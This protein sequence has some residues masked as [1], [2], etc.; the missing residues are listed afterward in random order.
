[1]FIYFRAGSG[2]FRSQ[3]NKSFL[4]RCIPK[5]FR[6]SISVRECLWHCA[7]GY[8]WNHQFW[9]KMCEGSWNWN[10]I[11][12]APSLTESYCLRNGESKKAGKLIKWWCSSPRFWNSRKHF[13]LMKIY[14]N[15]KGEKP[16]FMPHKDSSASKPS[17][18]SHFNKNSSI[19]N[20]ALIM[21]SHMRLAAQIHVAV[22]HYN[23]LEF[24]ARKSLKHKNKFF[25]WIRSTS[26][27]TSSA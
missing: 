7:F 22:S 16:R 17:K 9:G 25:K 21:M 24:Y 5:C 14:W 13:S 23:L 2:P 20:C 12:A 10:A 8:K 4:L 11:I 3:H 19:F 1:M 18:G 26:P 15:L 27:W 6:L